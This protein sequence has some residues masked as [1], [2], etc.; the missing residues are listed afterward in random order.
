MPTSELSGRAFAKISGQATEFINHLRVLKRAG[1][2]ST[3]YI[4]IDGAVKL[5]WYAR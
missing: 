3:A 5:P 2:L 1:K 4:D